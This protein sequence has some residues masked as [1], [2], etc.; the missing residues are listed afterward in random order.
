MTAVM[1]VEF[2]R[3]QVNYQFTKICVLQEGKMC[4]RKDLRDF[5]KGQ[6]VKARLL[7]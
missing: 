6:N 4:Q 2:I 5:D 3:Q 7:S 1:G